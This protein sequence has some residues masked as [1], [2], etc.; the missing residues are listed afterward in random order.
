M[1]TIPHPKVAFGDLADR[2][3]SSGDEVSVPRKLLDRLLDLYI[4]FW[5]FDEDWYLATYP[6]IQAAVAAGKF[7]SGRE[8]FKTVGYFEGRRGNQPIVDTE[9]YVEMYPDIA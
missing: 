4:S 2:L 6:D 5:D 1:V 8:H 9:W 3:K 7:G